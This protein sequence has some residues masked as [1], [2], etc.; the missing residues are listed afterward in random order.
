MGPLD[1]FIVIGVAIATPLGIIL[2]AAGALI[3]FVAGLAVSRRKVP[4]TI[5]WLLTVLLNAP[6]IIYIVRMPFTDG[7]EEG[8]SFEFALSL[9][10]FF[11]SGP[12]GVGWLAGFGL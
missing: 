9:L 6:S 12:F 8:G 2:V 1:G 7:R 10:V 5:Y 3:S 11:L 4:R